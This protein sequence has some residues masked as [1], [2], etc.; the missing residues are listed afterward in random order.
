MLS[1]LAVTALLGLTASA[2]PW[3]PGQ[4][5]DWGHG[6]GG[7]G[8][9]WGGNGGWGGHGQPPSQP[10][11]CTQEPFKFPLSNGFP[12]VEVGSPELLAIEKQA[13][14][15][16]PNGP[17]PSK[18]QDAT[19]TTLQLIAFNEIFEVAYFTSLLNNI[20]SGVYNVGSGAA[21]QI[22]ENAITAVQAQEELHALGANAILQ[23]AGRTTIQP[24][25]YVFPVSDFDSSIALASTFTD[26]VL[27]T[28][29]DALNNF[30]T[31]GD[32]EL[33]ALI[34]GVIGQEGEQNGF[35][36]NLGGKIPSQLPFLTRSAGPFAFSALN[37]MF[38]VQG[39][40]GNLDAIALP[41]F[42]PLTVATQNI[43][44][45][46]QD[47]SFSFKTNGTATDTSDL[48]IVYINQQNVPVV[49]P[50][51]NVQTQGDTV[52]FQAAFPFTE[53]LMFGLTIAAVTNSAG[54]F[55]GADDVA[56]KALYGPGL[57]EIQ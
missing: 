13:H 53:N 41:I 49:E 48:H 12:N 37:Q 27:G 50:L 47:L 9:G 25:E 11:N 1:Q 40:C 19:A 24:C 2:A 32:D 17:L 26:V 46:D 3:G 34:G 29:Q 55:A 54:P 18:I 8:N 56:A 5:G 28:L 33:L 36:R 16:L 52:S 30:G 23:T 51:K 42:S 39:T 57:I 21:K 44:A 38:V 15:T 7:N 22:V 6:N 43:Q 31:D 10:E 14:G 4:G 35:Y 20:T 45:Q